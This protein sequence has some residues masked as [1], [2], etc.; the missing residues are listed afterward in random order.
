[1]SDRLNLCVTI[2]WVGA[3]SGI[4]AAALVGL[5]GL[6]LRNLNDSTGGNIL[7]IVAGCVL[8]TW[9]CCVGS[10]VSWLVWRQVSEQKKTCT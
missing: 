7:L 3:L 6:L 9:C 10:L 8:V 1:M 4:P 2:C 5:A